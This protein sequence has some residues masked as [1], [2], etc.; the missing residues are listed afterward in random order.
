[1]KNNFFLYMTY[2]ILYLVHTLIQLML[3][4][5]ET[6]TMFEAFFL[7]NLFAICIF[8]IVVWMEYVKSGLNEGDK[9]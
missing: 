2:M 8:S 1:M 4:I 9:N 3:V 5:N 6:Q 7:S